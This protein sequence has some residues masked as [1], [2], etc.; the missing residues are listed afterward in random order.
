MEYQAIPQVLNGAL[1]L[2][3]NDKKYVI[4]VEE[5]RIITTAKWM[6]A[7]FF[8]PNTVTDEVL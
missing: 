8:A 2:N 4:T 5:N 3:G 6:D 1:A 7:V